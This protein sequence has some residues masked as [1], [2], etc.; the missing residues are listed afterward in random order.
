MRRTSKAFFGLIYT[1][2]RHHLVEKWKASTSSIEISSYRHLYIPFKERGTLCV[3]SFVG[4]IRNRQSAV[5][6]C[7]CIYSRTAA[8]FSP[9]PFRSST[10]SKTNEGIW[11]ERGESER[12][13]FRERATL[14]W[15]L[16][17]L[18]DLFVERV[19]Y[20]SHRCTDMASFDFRVL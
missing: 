6:N 3:A 8:N 15:S 18:V 2:A 10:T 16:A 17:I 12:R 4:A 13:Q 14:A 7:C 1:L 11:G 5:G 9:F 19:E 20:C